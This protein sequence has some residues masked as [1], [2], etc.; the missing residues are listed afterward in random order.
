MNNVRTATLA[1]SKADLGIPFEGGVPSTGYP[2]FRARAG[3][4]R[5]D[6]CSRAIPRLEGITNL[7]FAPSDGA[8]RR[9]S[10][11]WMARWED[12]CCLPVG[13]PTRQG[14]KLASTIWAVCN[15]LRRMPCGA[16]LGRIGG[17]LL[18]SPFPAGKLEF[19]SSGA[20][21]AMTLPT[22]ATMRELKTNG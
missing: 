21:R 12:P 4:P 14:W 10:T 6:L 9:A 13:V 3:C 15:F 20:P 11:R 8:K 1:D 18:E 16:W 17:N 2:W 7:W 5:A 22:R 19:C